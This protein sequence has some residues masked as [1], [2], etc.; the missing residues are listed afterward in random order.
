MAAPQL[1]SVFRDDP[2]VIAIGATALRFQWVTFCFHGWI[3][4]SSMMTQTIGLTGPATFL[5]VA[6]QGLFFIPLVWILSS[7]FGLPGIQMTQAAADLLTLV[8]SIP[9]QITA[10]R[11]MTD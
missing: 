3:V 2:D 9:I 7:A 6:R 5:A 8:V 4:M 1:I 10:M 11:H